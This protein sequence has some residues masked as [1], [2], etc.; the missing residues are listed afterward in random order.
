LVVSLLDMGA[1]SF[2]AVANYEWS[3]SDESQRLPIYNP[4][5]GKIITTV[6]CGNASTASEA[7]AKAQIAF[8]KWSQ[9]PAIERAALMNK[10]AAVLEEHGEELATLLCLENGKPMQDALAYDVRFASGAFRYFAS[11]IDKLPTEF[12]DRGAHYVH[13]VRE[14]HGVCVGILPFNWPP[15]HT[16]GKTAPALAA[17]NTMILKPGEQAPLTVMK[18]V[19]LMQTVFPEG[20]IQA[21]PG[22]GPEVPQTLVGSPIVKMVSFT[23]ATKTG[24]II[25]QA[26]SKQVKPLALELGGK[27]AMIIF[28]DAD[29]DR[30]V[31]DALQGGYF[32]KGEACTASSRMIVQKGVYE[33]F[34]TKLSAAV[35]RLKAGNGMNKDTHVGPC[36]SSQQ[37]DRVLDFI[38]IGQEEG[39]EIAA[40]ADLPSDPECKDGYFVKPTLFKGVKPEMVIAQEEI[41]GPVVTVTSFETEEEAVKIS[42]SV[43]YGLVGSIFSKDMDKAFRVSR[44]LQVGMVMLNNYDRNV[45]GLPFGGVKD[46]GYGRE[47][48]IDTLE[49]W[50]RKK[51]VQMPSGRGS[52]PMWRAIESCIDK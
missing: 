40:Q 23:G 33:E 20:V 6:Q 12:H 8:E 42:N 29:V 52:G 35:I 7:I 44:R 22:N 10:C 15:I 50:T 30:A 43:K 9:T 11:L 5:T 18:M 28:D 41:F 24:A 1:P 3:S 45:L 47:H 14:P 48:T 13:V 34:V 32:N 26:A 17:G 2:P 4:A 21:V 27:N 31:K 49:E 38:R 46:S 36:V 39:A 25:A 16:A 37:R 19:E 51:F